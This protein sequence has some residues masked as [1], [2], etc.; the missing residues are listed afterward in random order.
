MIFVAYPSTLSRRSVLLPSGHRVHST[1][2]QLH[3]VFD[4]TVHALQ[5]ESATALA[6]G[7]GAGYCMAAARWG[8]RA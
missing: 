3:C 5:Q 8:D 7:F 4:I 2:V 1:R 6:A